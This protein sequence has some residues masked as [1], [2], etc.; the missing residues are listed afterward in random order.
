MR[1]WRFPSG[2]A[3][4]SCSMRSKVGRFRRWR[5]SW[6]SPP[7][8]RAGTSTSPCAPSGRSSPDE[9]PRSEEPAPCLRPGA[10]A[11]HDADREGA[12]QGGARDDD[13]SNVAIV[14]SALRVGCGHGSDLR[15]RG[16][17][18]RAPRARDEARGGARCGAGCT[19]RRGAVA[20]GP[21]RG[22]PSLA[23]EARPSPPRGPR[24]HPT[25]DAYRLHRPRRHPH[26]LV[27]RILRR[28]GARLMNARTLVLPLVLISL[29]P[30]ARAASYAVRYLDLNDALMAL[31]TRIPELGQDCHVSPRRT[32][33]PRTA[34]LA[35][36]LAI[37]RG[38]AGG[39][40]K[41]A[42]ALE[43]IDTP[44]PTYRFHVA[45]L[46]ASRKEGTEPVLPPSELKAL[47]DFKK[48]MTYRSFQVEAETIVQSDREAQAQ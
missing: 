6:A 18:D 47:S 37:A 33:D 44:P 15:G 21:D 14:G 10:R 13:T 25:H 26:P 28:E 23:H 16:R 1:C 11:R 46:Q 32:S 39:Q 20:P 9:P 22:V 24:R 19:G 4:S 48:V 5:A 34:G 40:A 31:G 43:A 29:A 3:P 27:R 35:G 42:P 12:D 36:V 2:N 45:V 41:V 7:S 30:S 38:A 17:L 8:P